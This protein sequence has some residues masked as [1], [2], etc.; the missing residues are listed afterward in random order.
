M[1]LYHPPP[2]P[3]SEVHRKVNEG[4]NGKLDR[5]QQIPT[6]IPTGIPG[7]QVYQQILQCG[8]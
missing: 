8:W 2:M 7:I 6:D 1:P 5:Y 4:K 3:N